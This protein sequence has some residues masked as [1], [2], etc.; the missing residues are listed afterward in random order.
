MHSCCTAGGYWFPSLSF[1]SK[2]RSKVIP[3]L[4]WV[5]S[6]VP[7]ALVL[8]TPDCPASLA[9]YY[10]RRRGWPENVPVLTSFTYVCSEVTTRVHVSRRSVVHT[11]SIDWFSRLINLFGR[12]QV[13]VTSRLLCVQY[14]G[15]VCS[16]RRT[17]AGT[18]TDSYSQL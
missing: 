7:A 8:T 10:T 4:R 1:W 6:P 11:A 14:R 9:D 17:G 2:V 5:F 3:H 13:F 12:N 18:I 16:G 15:K